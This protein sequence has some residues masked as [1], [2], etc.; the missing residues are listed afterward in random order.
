MIDVKMDGVA[1]CQTDWLAIALN[2]LNQLPQPKRGPKRIDIDIAHRY[3]NLVTSALVL[4]QRRH[5]QIVLDIYHIGRYKIKHKLGQYTL[6]G[7]RHYWLDWF[8]QQPSSLYTI[9]QTGSNMREENT[10]VKLNWEFLGDLELENVPKEVIIE[11]Y[12]QHEGDLTATPV[13]VKSLRLY[14]ERTREAIRTKQRWSKKQQKMVYAYPDWIAKAKDNLKTAVQ[15]ARLT[16]NGSLDQPMK[17]SDFGRMYLSGINLQ[18]CSKTVRH[19]ALGHCYSIDFSVCSTAWRLHTAQQIDPKF[20]AKH[21][22]R[23]IKNK[24]QFRWDLAKVL[25]DRHIGNAKRILT[26]IGFGA[27]MNKKAWPMDNGLPGVPA[28]KEGLNEDQIAELE[29]CEWFQ[30]FMQ[31]QR[32]MNDMICDHMLKDLKKEEIMDCVK[33]AAGR[34]Q[35]NKVLAFLY[36]HAEME[37]LDNLLDY[38]SARF[39]R[40]EILLTTH[41]CVYIKHS[42]NMAEVNSRL[43][44]MNPYLF[45]E[46]TE[47]WGHFDPTAEVPQADQDPH[48]QQAEAFL[49]YWRNKQRNEGYYDGSNTGYYSG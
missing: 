4:N 30:E 22:L 5:D 20:T 18:S 48:K 38:I 9:V 17:F 40:D 1:C 44:H 34:I 37:Y 23:L 7:K 45:A 49:N 41:D 31:E 19:A 46:R 32:T 21:T 10:Q 29:V 24:Q 36:Q 13:D 12:R 39:G 47:H 35:R 14:I 8:E 3:F 2:D 6:N 27:D 16:E 43:N 33:D 42:I 28:I 11:H 26:A 25:G 15:I